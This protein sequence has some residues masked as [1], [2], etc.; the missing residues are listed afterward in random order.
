MFNFTG[1]FDAEN[2]YTKRTWTER[3]DENGELSVELWAN[4]DSLISSKYSC[5]FGNEVVFFTV[6][7][8]EGEVE[9]SDLRMQDAGGG[10]P[11]PTS[12]NYYQL[13][14]YTGSNNFQLNQVVSSPEK[15]MLFINGCKAK[16]SQDFNI[17][18]STLNWLNTFGLDNSD[19]IE[20]YY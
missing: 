17:N 5:K 2:Q 13:L 18:S 20:V 4:E 14:Q 19:V 7:A 15:A 6:E 12:T 1:G 3:T 8:G 16:F 9:L 11:P 10:D